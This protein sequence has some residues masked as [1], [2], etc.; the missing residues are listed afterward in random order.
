M[1]FVPFF[2]LIMEGLVDENFLVLMA[3]YLSIIN[4]V[5]VLSLS[6]NIVSL[7]NNN[8][9]LIRTWPI[10]MGTYL[11][12]N[13][14]VSTIVT[15]GL[16]AIIIFIMGLVFGLGPGPIGL[17]IGSN[18][19]LTYGLSIGMVYKDYKNIYIGW[20]SEADLFTRVSKFRQFVQYTLM[21]FVASFAV[22]LL[23]LSSFFM[24]TYIWLVL[25]LGS[26]LAGLIAYIIYSD[27]LYYLST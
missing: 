15:S 10:D 5:Y 17:A 22:G 20:H 24:G 13:A 14:Q 16:G 26:L 12:Y 1:A 19:A 21:I 2:S 25:G 3:I 18:L 4:T 8:F 9:E 27:K 11:I 7:D 6:R 23:S